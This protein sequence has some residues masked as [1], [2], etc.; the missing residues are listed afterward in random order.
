MKNHTNTNPSE[1]NIFSN[2][3][4]WL[5]I[6]NELEL[7]YS[8]IVENHPIS[9]EV[10]GMMSFTISTAEVSPFLSVLRLFAM[11]TC[12]STRGIIFWDVPKGG[13]FSSH[14]MFDTVVAAALLLLFMLTVIP[15]HPPLHLMKFALIRSFVF[16]L[17]NQ[18]IAEHYFVN[19]WGALKELCLFITF[20]IRPLGLQ[21][22]DQR[23][24]C[25]C[26]VIYTEST[27]ALQRMVFIHE[28]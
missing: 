21:L 8:Y 9:A 1:L 3:Y 4:N 19:W 22:Y 18:S 13:L 12:R 14:S 6:G 2:L 24:A 10:N 17:T 15:L 20:I 7:H 11:P 16:G 28:S 25:C 5:Y 27:T 26:F 23:H